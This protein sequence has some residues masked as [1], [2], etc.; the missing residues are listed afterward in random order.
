MV[1]QDI[2]RIGLEAAWIG[3]VHSAMEI[4]IIRKHCRLVFKLLDLNFSGFI[5][6]NL[7]FQI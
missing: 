7:R 5:F 3:M 4:L 1:Q 2:W 6:L